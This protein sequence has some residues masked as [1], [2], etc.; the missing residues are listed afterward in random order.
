ME[1]QIQHAP[2]LP[3][4]K[5]AL[6][7]SHRLTFGIEKLDSILELHL[8]YIIGIVGETRYTNALV[9]R[10]IVRSLM[11][12]RHGGFDAQKVIVIDLDNSSNPYLCV[13]FARQYGMHP[14][15]VLDNVLVS[16]QFQIYQLMNTIIYELPKRVQLHHP[17]VIIISGLLDQFLQEPNIDVEEFERLISQIV[18]ALR[19][20]KD[21]L[22]IISSRFGVDKMELPTLPRIIEIRD[23]IEF[24]GTK[25][26]FSIYNNGRLK[27]VSMVENE[28]NEVI[29]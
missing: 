16:R 3:K 26:N 6:E 10:L 15:S 25:L 23:K 9:T 28:L 18:P 4:F 8:D 1:S 19:R 13:N 17:K 5:T 14:D 2:E 22:I 24:D 29:V 20:M 7:F 21:V 12:H 11:P 27:R